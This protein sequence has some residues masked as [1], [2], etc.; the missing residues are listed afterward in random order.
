MWKYHDLVWGNIEGL[1]LQKI[2]ETIRASVKP[3]MQVI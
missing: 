1:S 2:I 3:Q